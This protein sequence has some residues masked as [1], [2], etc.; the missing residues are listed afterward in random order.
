VT[1][2]GQEVRARSAAG[3]RSR[4]DRVVG[5]L[6]AAGSGSRLGRPKAL[7]TDPAGVTW[8]AS[9]VAAL[10]GGGCGGVYVVIGAAA[11]E[12]RLH[13]PSE[14]TAV[15]A[16]DWAEGMGASLR[17]GLAALADQEPAATAAVVMLV[18]TPDVSAEVVRRLLAVGTGAE[19]LGRASYH[20]TAGHPVLLGRDHWAG[21]L[22]S[23]GGDR[24]ARD[25]L[26][27]RKV[28]IVECG[29]VA[30]GTDI[31]TPP[32]LTTWLAARS[33]PD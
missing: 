7:V 17:A 9:A 11:D 31:D 25:Y 19:S 10:L 23:A 28:T 14:A 6:L 22:G 3:D 5:L 30:D 24:G 13:L 2:R 20:G 8:M 32:G 29:D 4:A 21:V 26:T 12:V 16:E 15:V 18:D 27:L 33:R 1:S